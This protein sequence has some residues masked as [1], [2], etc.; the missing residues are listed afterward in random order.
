APPSC[1]IQSHRLTLLLSGRHPCWISSWT[2]ARAYPCRRV[3]RIAHAESAGP[4]DRR[5]ALLPRVIAALL[6]PVRALGAEGSRLGLAAEQCR[7]HGH[8]CGS[9]QQFTH[10]PL[11]YGC[12]GLERTYIFQVRF[13]W[14]IV[15]SGTPAKLFASK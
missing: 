11:P 5:S 6:A 9:K 10:E 4:A 3:V 8:D 13:I 15:D 1:L 12:E 2:P 7:E 14:P